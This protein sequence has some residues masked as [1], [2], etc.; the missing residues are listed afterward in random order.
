MSRAY[1]VAVLGMVSMPFLLV[2]TIGFLLWRSTKVPPPPP[3][4]DPA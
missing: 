2:A 4:P 1:S 3:P